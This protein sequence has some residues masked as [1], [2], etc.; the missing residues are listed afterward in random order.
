MADAVFEK[1]LRIIILY[2]DLKKAYKDWKPVE[3]SNPIQESKDTQSTLLEMALA[4]PSAFRVMI[5]AGYE[6]LVFRTHLIQYKNYERLKAIKDQQGGKESEDVVH[7]PSNAYYHDVDYGGHP[8]PNIDDRDDIVEEIVNIVQKSVGQTKA[9]RIAIRNDTEFISVEESYGKKWKHSLVTY[10]KVAK[11]TPMLLTRMDTG[12]IMGKAKGKDYREIFPGIFEKWFIKST[13]TK[14]Y[15]ALT[16]LS[17]FPELW[18]Y[19]KNFFMGDVIGRK[20]NWEISSFIKDIFKKIKLPQSYDIST[21]KSKREYTH[22]LE[23]EI[24]RRS[25]KFREKAQK[26]PNELTAKEIRIGQSMFFILFRILCE[27]LGTTILEWKKCFISS[28]IND[29]SYGYLPDVNS[30]GDTSR[31]TLLKTINELIRHGVPEKALE[32]LIIKA[33]EEGYDIDTA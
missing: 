7:S 22:Q 14:P 29:I 12:K 11:G 9:P 28:K 25:M 26:S 32:K 23:T 6:N 19:F 4:S 2:L 16:R 18:L 17:G 21:E 8:L 15:Y 33:R 27:A 20:E 30:I 3:E 5:K 31:G 24:L 1:D 13:D 10:D